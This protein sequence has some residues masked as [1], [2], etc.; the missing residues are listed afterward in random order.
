M[1]DLVVG[2]PICDVACERYIED[3]YS[4]VSL[5]EN[6]NIHLVVFN[7]G[8]HFINSVEIKRLKKLILRSK[9]SCI[10]ITNQPE[11]ESLQQLDFVLAFK[12][13]FID[14]YLDDSIRELRRREQ[15]KARYL[16]IAKQKRTIA[17]YTLG[18]A[19]LLEPFIKILYLKLST[20][21]DFKVVF[22]VIF[23][24]DNPVS[25]LEFW[26]LFPLAGIALLRP[27]ASSL[28]IFLSVQIYSIYSYLTFEEF[29]WPFVQQSPHISSTFL[30]CCNMA[31]LVYLV[32]PENRKPYIFKSK[33]IFRKHKRINCELLG[34]INSPLGDKEICVKNLSI[35]GAMVKTSED[36][37]CGSS[38]KISIEGI[39]V[40]GRVMRVIE[41]SSNTQ[42]LYGIQFSCLNDEVGELI[43]ILE[44]RKAIRSAA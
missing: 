11:L 13:E 39:S 17:F 26:A 29:T 24:I 44:K 18:A 22:D 34:M 21:F 31:L 23:S 20:G 12:P 25:F 7:L 42:T 36:L 27:A 32:I 38:I 43:K 5:L 19:L 14:H 35:S 4:G 16:E 10:F 41:F 33:H 37:V 9:V 6:S 15:F 3:F 8:S 40:F 2:A 1:I 30:L 28:F